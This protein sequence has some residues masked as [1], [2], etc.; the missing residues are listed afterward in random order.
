M[1]LIFYVLRWCVLAPLLTLSNSHSSSSHV[2]NGS[3]N[4]ISGGK[5][6]C[7]KEVD[8]DKQNGES[9]S[10]KES[11]LYSQLHLALL[12]SLVENVYPSTN[13]VNNVKVQYITFKNFQALENCFSS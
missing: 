6:N 12:E 4:C 7:I 10:D 11:P 8:V 13:R 3:S 5:N 1:N 2:S 9:H